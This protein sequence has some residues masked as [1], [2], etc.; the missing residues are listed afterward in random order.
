VF[1]NYG[2]GAVCRYDLDGTRR[3]FR[4][5]KPVGLN[6]GHSASP[7]LAD[8]K[9][10]VYLDGLTALDAQTGRTIWENKA[11][12]RAYGCPVLMTLGQT[13][14][15]ITPTGFVT[16]LS[17]GKVLARDIAKGLGGDEF[18]IS[19]LVQGDVVYYIDSTCTAVRLAMEGDT[20]RAKT[21]WTAEL[22]EAAIG[23]PAF[24]D[25]LI[26]ACTKTAHYSVLD[27]GTGKPVLVDPKSGKLLD[28]CILDLAPAGGNSKELTT[29]SVY[30]SVTVAGKCVYV[31]NDMGQTFVL[32]ASKT[33]KEIQRNRLPKGSGASLFF[34]GPDVFLRG[35]DYVY[36]VGP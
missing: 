31:S 6:Y 28:D 27:A 14:V 29:A 34:D 21:L 22:V 13:K 24:H 12:K 35:G 3:W 25:G 2:S 17:D 16:R 7:L 36:R 33:F 5:V 10:V 4:L 1:V 30:P 23:S 8:G 11:V 19:P 15:V 32:E 26:F 18:S 9:L 20:V